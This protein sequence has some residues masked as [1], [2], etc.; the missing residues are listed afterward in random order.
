MPSLPTR[1]GRLVLATAAAL[2]LCTA[3]APALDWREV[4]PD[5]TRLVGLLPCKPTAQE[6]RVTLAGSP[7]QLGLL[8]CAADGQTW[9]LAWADVT[10][11][12]RVA[13]ALDELA[14]SA[15]ANVGASGV[16]EQPAQVP[17]ATP[18]TGSRRLVLQGKGGSGQPVELRAQVFSHGTQVFQATALGPQ[19]GA[20]AIDTFFGGLRV[21]P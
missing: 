13:S 7:V 20:E 3:C 19:L 14:R 5:G 9:G 8:A 17:G 10:D 18:Q 4:R 2:L 16:R 11:P 12:A 15:A 21:T 1:P 6:R